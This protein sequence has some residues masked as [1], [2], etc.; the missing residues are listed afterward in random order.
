VNFALLL[1]LFAKLLFGS[2]LRIKIVGLD[3]FAIEVQSI[4][5]KIKQFM[6]FSSIITIDL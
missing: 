3:H 6:G 4:L 5:S 1:P 2:L